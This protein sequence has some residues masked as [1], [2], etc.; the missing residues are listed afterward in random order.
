MTR[1]Y[2]LSK[3]QYACRCGQEHPQLTR[4]AG[5]P[6]L[7]CPSCPDDALHIHIDQVGGVRI[8]TGEVDR[9]GQLIVRANVQIDLLHAKV[10]ALALLVQQMGK[11]P[12]PEERKKR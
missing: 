8:V 3:Q 6:V 4:L 10:E 9:D 7:L 11:E 1:P 2:V 12:E 5:V